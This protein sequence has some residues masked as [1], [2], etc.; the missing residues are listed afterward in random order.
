MFASGFGS[1]SRVSI[2]TVVFFGL[3]VSTV[4]SLFVVPVIYRI[5]KGWELGWIG[6][7]APP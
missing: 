2:G 4:L 1:G 5:V 7:L 6:S 3:F